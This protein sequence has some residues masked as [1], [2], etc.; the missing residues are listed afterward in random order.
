MV[1]G[2]WFFVHVDR[3]LCTGRA[4]VPGNPILSFEAVHV[5]AYPTAGVKAA[6]DRCGMLLF[7]VAPTKAA[8]AAATCAVPCDLSM[9]FPLC[10]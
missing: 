4:A 2:G 1:E 3:C 9:R 5:A 6:S 8:W 7:L 10:C